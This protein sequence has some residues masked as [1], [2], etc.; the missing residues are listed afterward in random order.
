MT[1]PYL[2]TDQLARRWGLTK[3]AL[4]SQRRRKQGPSYYMVNRLGLPLGESLVRYKLADVLAFELAYS[5]T[6]LQP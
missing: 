6:P 1:E 5:I 4:K 3:N 2:T